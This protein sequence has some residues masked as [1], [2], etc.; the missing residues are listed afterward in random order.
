MRE[1][2][3]Q[4]LLQFATNGPMNMYQ[5]WHSIPKASRSSRS[6]YQKAVDFLLRVGLIRV[7][8]SKSWY[9]KRS[10]KIYQLTIE[11]FLEILKLNNLWQNLEKTIS[12]NKE[13]LPEYFDMWESFKQFNVENV[14]IKLVRYAARKL[15][16]G[17]PSFPERIE[18]RTPTLRDW[19]P[20]LAIYPYQAL[21]EEVISQG[22][23]QRWHRMLLAVPKAE[24]LYVSTLKWIVASHESGMKS[25]SKALEVHYKYKQALASAKWMSAIIRSKKH[26]V[27]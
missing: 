21:I 6:S 18:D 1:R 16:N 10:Q 13:I 9:G 23:A 25:Y 27:S 14:A 26:S 8:E 3:I 22:E 20:R 2:Q 11:G 19:L 5:V 7:R 17:L 15:Q 24:Q 12:S 4:T